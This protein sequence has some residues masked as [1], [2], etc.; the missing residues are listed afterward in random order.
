M[1]KAV[2]AGLLATSLAAPV[3]AYAQPAASPSAAPAATTE[4]IMVLRPA[5]WLVIG[6][7][8]VAGAVVIDA[9]IPTDLAYIA[10]GI[11]G[12]YLANVWYNGRQIELHM[13]TVPKT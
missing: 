2:L 7:G 12:G 13:G 9:L 8:V 1:Q 4:Q 10:G 3:G 5:Q 11:V 6:A